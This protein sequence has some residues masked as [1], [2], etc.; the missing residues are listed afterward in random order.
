MSGTIPDALLALAAWFIKN[1][2]IIANALGTRPVLMVL[3]HCCQLREI[4][5]HEHERLENTTSLVHKTT[6]KATSIL[7]GSTSFCQNRCLIITATSSEI[8]RIQK[9][10]D[11]TSST[12][13]P[14]L[15]F[16]DA[17]SICWSLDGVRWSAVPC[18][19]VWFYTCWD[20]QNC[21]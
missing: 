15:A 18:A 21:R 6:H 5:R 3:S 17:K 4:K 1:E 8:A 13:L 14:A 2:K 12:N 19:G 16:D 11:G 9:P 10:A 7:I 20:F